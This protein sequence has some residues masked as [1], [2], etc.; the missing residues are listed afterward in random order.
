MSVGSCSWVKLQ[1]HE[2]VL[3][4]IKTVQK[5]EDPPDAAHLDV[6]HAYERLMSKISTQL[7]HTARISICCRVEGCAFAPESR[8]CIQ[9]V[10]EIE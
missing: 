6:L 8:S 5:G 10:F 1:G 9:V 2:A 3:T 4:Q 7:C